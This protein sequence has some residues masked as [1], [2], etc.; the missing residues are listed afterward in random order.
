MDYCT[1]ELPIRIV[2]DPQSGYKKPRCQHCMNFVHPQSKAISKTIDPIH[3][4][5]SFGMHE[6][7]LALKINEILDL[8]K[9]NGDMETRRTL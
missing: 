5:A 2:Y 3:I 1:C 4:D 9:A 6:E 8:L 7:T